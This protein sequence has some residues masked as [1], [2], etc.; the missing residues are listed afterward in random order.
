M[1]LKAVTPRI[2]PCLGVSPY[3]TTFYVI[4]QLQDIREAVERDLPDHEKSRISY[5][6]EIR[7]FT[8]FFSLI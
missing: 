3:V 5:L 7:D 8:K 1:Q 2:N 6:Y 4:H